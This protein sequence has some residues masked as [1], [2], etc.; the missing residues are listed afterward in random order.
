MVASGQDAPMNDA[1]I[2]A[3]P[4]PRS[5]NR[6]QRRLS[7]RIVMAFHLACDRG[8]LE[9]ADRLLGILERMLRRPLPNGHPEA[10]D[11]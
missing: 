9:V 8:D 7:D 2:P 11:H 6:K 3:D 1:D 5:P 10:G 4:P